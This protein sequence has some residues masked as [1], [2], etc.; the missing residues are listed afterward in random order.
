MGENDV[1]LSLTIAGGRPYKRIYNDTVAAAIQQ[2]CMMEGAIADAPTQEA[3]M[4]QL[5]ILFQHAH[6]E[7]LSGDNLFQTNYNLWLL[8]GYVR[9][10]LQTKDLKMVA[11]MLNLDSI[12]YSVEEAARFDEQRVDTDF[13]MPKIRTDGK[14]LK[15]AMP[16]RDTQDAL[17]KALI[18]N[19][20][21]LAGFIQT[22]EDRL[23]KIYD[24]IVR[25]ASQHLH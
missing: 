17:T 15:V 20:H 10:L 25:Q 7:L 13:K 4:R 16:D 23:K 9:M 6:V 19:L 14:K 2:F 18:T 12:L 8:N 3:R 21:T 1:Q 24:A 11:Q 5:G 22:S